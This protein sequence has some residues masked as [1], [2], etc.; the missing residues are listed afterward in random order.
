M[1][2][3][4]IPLAL[5]RLVFGFKRFFSHI[6]C[7]D[8]N[9][10]LASS[11]ALLGFLWAVTDA[12]VDQWTVVFLQVILNEIYFSNNWFSALAWW[13]ERWTART[14]ASEWNVVSFHRNFIF[15]VISNTFFP[16]FSESFDSRLFLLLSYFA[17]ALTDIMIG[18]CWQASQFQE[19]SQRSCPGCLWPAIEVQEIRTSFTLPELPH[20][21]LVHS[22]HNRGPS[23]D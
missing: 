8:Q 18:F 7:I 15:W 1:D 22:G 10:L 16:P 21:L 23:P 12:D 19:L 20:G 6:L 17:V 9:Y 2:A 11:P 3:A 13:E 4:S 5:L 14:L